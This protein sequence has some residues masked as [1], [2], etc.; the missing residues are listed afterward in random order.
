MTSQHRFRLVPALLIASGLVLLTACSSTP[1]GTLSPV[2][3][4]AASST[5]EASTPKTSTTE[6]GSAEESAVETSAAE[7]PTSAASTNTASYRPIVELFSTPG[8]CDPAGNTLEMTACLLKQVQKADHTVDS[9]QRNRFEQAAD[10]E[11]A[12]LLADDATWLKGRT[13][14]CAANR[15]GGSIDQITAAD[16]LLKISKA[17]VTALTAAS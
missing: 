14:T 2:S 12:A 9:L 16:C 4:V 7:Q 10:A 1:T 11:Q 6:A 5:P 15:T 8:R 3:D 17:R 13:T